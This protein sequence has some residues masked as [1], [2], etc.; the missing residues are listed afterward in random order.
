MPASK[1]MKLKS[2]RYNAI[3]SRPNPAEK[4]N[5]EKL[6]IISKDEP[7]IQRQELEIMTAV[8]EDAIKQKKEGN[9]RPLYEL[10]RQI[11]DTSKNPTK[12]TFWCLA[13]SRTIHKFDATC[14]DLI[15]AL[16]N[17]DWT[18]H[19]NNLAVAYVT[20]LAN[21][22]AVYPSRAEAML[23]M[24]VQNFL[25]KEEVSKMEK[26]H[27]KVHYAI[28]FLLPSIPQEEK[29]LFNI[30][31]REFPHKRESL[32]AYIVYVKN[33]LQ[34]IE[35]TPSLQHRILAL[36][37]ERMIEL[38]TEVQGQI[39]EIEDMEEGLDKFNI[40]LH[41]AQD[42]STDF[43]KSKPEESDFEVFDDANADD[44][45]SDIEDSAPI[46]I[47]VDIANGIQKLDCI[48]KLVLD[49]LDYSHKN[50]TQEQQARLTET[51]F[52][53]FKESILCT[54][55]TRYIQFIPFWY[56][57]LNK[58]YASRFIK[59]LLD[60]LINE[61][62]KEIIREAAAQYI[63]SYIARAKYLDVEE[64]TW[65]MRVLIQ[66]AGNYVSA[67]ENLIRVR[68]ESKHERFYLIVQ[69]VMYIFCFRWR[70]F[71]DTTSGN[72]NWSKEIEIIKNII[73]SV[74]CPLKFCV[75]NTVRMFTF[76]SKTI[77][78]MTCKEYKCIKT[79]NDSVLSMEEYFPFD[80][81]RLK[82]SQ[83]YLEGLYQA[84]E[85]ISEGLEV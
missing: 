58:S 55:K 69:T 19:D 78:F 3:V 10:I 29:E 65:C 72:N 70:D 33:L 68:D 40:G 54:I 9:K 46:V 84:W 50:G 74:F 49:Y 12:L 30:L 76:I 81:F 16:L 63:A 18:N 60:K 83:T 47:A 66:W 48:I 79:K 71:C 45:D 42:G 64:V 77:G 11:T 43:Y 59:L 8:I 34:L 13:F 41:S 21:L 27:G 14:S 61:E 7:N 51:I 35:Y 73:E 6:Q 75:E 52:I 53:I 22:V 38:D 4:N 5:V 57:S 62:G 1:A 2:A 85:D 15:Y 56:F 80:P 36:I 32:G 37:F 24:L 82:T 17:F 20:M 31:Y 39:D 67:H 23:E 25:Y 28:K 44:S 26:I